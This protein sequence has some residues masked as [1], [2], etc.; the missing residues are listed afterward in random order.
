MVILSDLLNELSAELDPALLLGI[1]AGFGVLVLEIILTRMGRIM[2]KGPKRVARAK[3]MGHVVQ[4]TL[5]DCWYETKSDNSGTRYVYHGKY[6]YYVNG[7]KY[8]KKMISYHG[9]PGPTATRY[10]DDD[11]SRAYLEEEMTKQSA[12]GCLIILIPV[13]VAVVVAMLL[14]YRG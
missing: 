7:V 2:S 5:E 1:I 11:P 14:G 13:V 12:G 9:R 3:A 8:I 6:A 10:Y 4:G